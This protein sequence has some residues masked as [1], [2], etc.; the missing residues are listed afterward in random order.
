MCF[1]KHALLCSS[2][3][4]ILY[5]GN[6]QLS[7]DDE[8]TFQSIVNGYRSPYYTRGQRRLSV[9]DVYD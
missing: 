5:A 8:N 9:Y 1:K 3:S 6:R 7:T 4:R 2:H